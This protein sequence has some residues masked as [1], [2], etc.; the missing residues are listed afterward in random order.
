M[1]KLA[2]ISLGGDG[3]GLAARLADGLE[4]DLYL[5]E[6]CPPPQT[7]EG[8]PLP[9]RFG[10]V[11]DL[12]AEIFRRYAGLIYVMPCGV[13]VR[14]IAP[15][16]GSKLSDPA[17]VVL[18]AAARHAVSLLSGHEGGANE[19][20]L[21][22]GNLCGAEPVISTTTEAVKRIIAGIGCRKGVGAA[23]IVEA[24]KMALAGA[25]LKAGDIR[26]LAT[27]G[28]KAAEPGLLAAAQELKLPLRIIPDEDI[29][30]FTGDFTPSEFVRAKTGLPG[31]C[32]PAALLAGRRCVLIS[33]KF[34]HAG[35]TVALARECCG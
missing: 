29:R 19:L 2:V 24:L 27:G 34:A 1:K 17:V 33:K 20:A 5:H 35:V 12:S 26:L 9:R 3:G 14:A 11:I 23:T 6:D 30:N 28:I 8:S 15:L 7:P 22:V 13:V 25:G 16:L 31:V 32:E 21:R 10:R 18:D 4:A